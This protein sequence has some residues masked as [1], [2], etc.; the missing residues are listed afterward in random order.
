MKRKRKQLIACVLVLCLSAGG[1]LL[2]N[3]FMLSSHEI[4][5]EPT[6][7]VGEE[8]AAYAG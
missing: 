3:H 6:E 7:M 5:N 2:W 1:G 4:A 8:F